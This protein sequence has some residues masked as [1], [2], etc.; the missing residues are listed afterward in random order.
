MGVG[1][2]DVPFV[3]ALCLLPAPEQRPRHSGAV[4]AHN[5]PGI[6]VSLRPSGRMDTHLSA[7]KSTFFTLPPY[8]MSKLDSMW[9]GLA[10]LGAVTEPLFLISVWEQESASWALWDPQLPWSWASPHRAW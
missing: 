5:L 1:Q 4:L 10:Q 6:T 9:A 3:G 2:D 8:A 7:L